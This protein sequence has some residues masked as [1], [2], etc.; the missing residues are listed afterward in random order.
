MKN[1]A[2]DD[3]QTNATI[4]QL[5]AQAYGR[6]VPIGGVSD[7]TSGPQNIVPVEG[8]RN[9]VQV[10]LAAAGV[11]PTDVQVTLT[12]GATTDADGAEVVMSDMEETEGTESSGFPAASN[13]VRPAS[14]G[15][16]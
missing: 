10:A 7:G 4:V 13:V 8:V 5:A 6:L 11:T 3:T 15:R 12:G 1:P 2:T 14:E 9:A 16:P